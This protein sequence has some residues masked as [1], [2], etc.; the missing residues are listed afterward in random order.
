MLNN[1]CGQGRLGKDI[2]LRDA[3]G[4]KVAS[5]SIA[6]D[7]N[8]KP[9][10]GVRECDWIPIVAWNGLAEFV[11]KYFHKGDM[12][13]VNGRLQVRSYDDRDGNKR[14]TTEVVA[15]EINFCGSSS[16]S[17]D[18]NSQPAAGGNNQ[19]GSS[20]NPADYGYQQGDDAYD[21]FMNI[22]DDMDEDLPFM[23]PQ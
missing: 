23:N 14:W 15:R 17:G 19:P 3:A 9:R 1:W 18:G 10:D 13:T 21:G 7:R 6:C 4:H 11:E 8:Y 12:M 5:F 20:W 16:R 22:P 2:E